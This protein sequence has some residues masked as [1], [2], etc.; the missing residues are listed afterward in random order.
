M[1]N[2][3]ARVGGLLAVGTVLLGI[4]PTMGAVAAP[5]TATVVGTEQLEIRACPEVAC[6]VVATAPLGASV[7]VQIEETDATGEEEA[8]RPATG[9]PLQVEYQ[10]TTGYASDLYLATDPAHVPYFLQGEDGCQRVGLIF[11]IGVGQEPATSILDTLAAE[12][13]PAT[14]FVMG[15]WADQHPPVLQ[16]MVDEGYLIGS[17][18][19]DSIEFPS[20]SDEEVAEDV[21]RSREAIEHATGKPVDPYFTPYASAIDERTRAIVAAQGFLPV[22][23]TV[24]TADF[25]PDATEQSVY[26]RVME[27]VHDG[28]LVELHLEAINSAGSTALALPRIIRDLRAQGYQFVTVPEMMQPCPEQG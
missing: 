19:Y 7:T 10:G 15:W 26:D 23:W 16:R 25:S 20:R 18:G 11:N 4:V 14:M 2:R 1:V 6:D 27:G 22:A 21:Q 17:H 24:Y 5:A 13:V 9:R 28:A 3:L 8:A 12:Q